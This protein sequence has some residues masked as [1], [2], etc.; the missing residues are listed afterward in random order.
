MIPSLVG[1]GGSL[2][3]DA[4]H[5][6]VVLIA[7]GDGVAGR[8]RHLADVEAAGGVDCHLLVGGGADV[9]VVAQDAVGGQGLVFLGRAAENDQLAVAGRAGGLG[10]NGAALERGRSGQLADNAAAKEFADRLANGETTLAFSDFAGAEKIAYPSPPFTLSDAEGCDPEIGDVTIYK[11]WGNIAIFY[12][13]SSGYSSDLV[14]LGKIE[15]DGIGIFAAQS[16]D[17]TVTLRLAGD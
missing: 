12:R 14:Y 5:T 6:Q 2:E 9:D 16:G 8:D 11:P 17:F 1:S 3:D 13:D 4:A 10:K 15:G 7:L